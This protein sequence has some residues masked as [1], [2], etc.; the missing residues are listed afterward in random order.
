VRSG[1]RVARV[2]QVVELGIEPTV[3]AVA[4]LASRWKSESDVI[5]DGRQKIFLVARIA[6]SR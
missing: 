3:H 4:R 1:Q 2:L 5:D 6:R